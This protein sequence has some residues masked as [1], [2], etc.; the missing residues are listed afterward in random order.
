MKIKDIREA[1]NYLISCG[2]FR[3]DQEFEE[4]MESWK[5]YNHYTD[6]IKIHE[7]GGVS[8]SW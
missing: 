5:E 3:G 8:G 4:Y 2:F 7:D 6:T 1:E